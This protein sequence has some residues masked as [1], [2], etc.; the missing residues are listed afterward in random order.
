METNLRR[1]LV[2]SCGDPMIFLERPISATLLVMSLIVIELT[3]L[4]QLR[5]SREQA[6]Q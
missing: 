5:R 6:F 4:P 2:L 1:S 3:I